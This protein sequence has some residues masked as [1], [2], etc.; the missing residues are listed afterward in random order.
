MRIVFMGTPALAANTLEAVAADHEIALVATQPDR[1]A[2]RSHK[3]QPPPVKEWAIEHGIAVAQPERARDAEF[4]ARVEEARPEAIVVVAFGQIL[5]QQILDMPRLFFEH[6]TCVNLHYSLLP[7]W[8]GAAPVQRAIEHGD[9]VTGVSTQHM[10]A[11]LDAGDL[12]LSEQIEIGE[13]EIAGELFE[14]LIPLGTKVLLETLRLVEKGEASRVPQNESQATIAPSIKAEETKLDWQEPAAY[15]AH[16]IHAFNPRPGMVATF[17]DKP[18]KVWR[19][20]PVKST[21]KGSAGEIYIEDNRVFVKTWN[22]PHDTSKVDSGEA[23]ELI[24][25]QP[26]GKGRMKAS[27]WARGV[28]LEVGETLGQ[29]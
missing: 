6:G 24:E 26:A 28:R 29:D 10:A 13:E 7:R 23:L 8:R 3:L 25:V 19:A 5:P 15:L 11:K 9:H 2:G 20:R 14:R 4:V 22:L 16:K 18:M 12:I 1:P 27:D 17:R 21:F